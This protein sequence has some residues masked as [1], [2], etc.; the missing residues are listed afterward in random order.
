MRQKRMKHWKHINLE[1]LFI[2]SDY[3]SQ[4]S[5][6]VKTFIHFVLFTPRE[7]GMSDMGA[8][9][10]GGRR[11]RNVSCKE[12]TTK[13]QI[14]KSYIKYK[15]IKCKNSSLNSDYSI[16]EQECCILNN[17]VDEQQVSHR[18]VLYWLKLN[19]VYCS[20]ATWVKHV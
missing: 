19:I 13:L 5:E 2:K 12:V 3:C 1:I 17:S 20:I 8:R 10:L 18:T 16:S 15:N 6:M 11:G 4:L 9:W 7:D 14:N